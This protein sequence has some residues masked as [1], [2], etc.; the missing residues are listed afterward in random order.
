[1]FCPKCGSELTVGANFC[2][3]CGAPVSPLPNILNSAGQQ[4]QNSATQ[5]D[6]NAVN[7][8]GAF[9]AGVTQLA[10]TAATGAAQ[11]AG[12]AVKGKLI[13]ASIT[14]AIVVAGIILYNMFFVTKPLDI[15][16]QFINAVNEKDL[17]AA[18]SC[19]DPKYEKAYKATSGILSNFIGGVEITDI[20]DLF[21]LL[22]ELAGESSGDKTDLMLN[23]KG[24]TS[25][26][27]NEETA[28]ITLQLE[29]QATNSGGQVTTEEGP[30]TFYLKKF[31][32]GWRIVEIK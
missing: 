21:P 26:E 10:G 23:I 24:V 6:S 27:V 18:V 13:A 31:N 25:Q 28:V 11:V 20:A 5:I 2:G 4:V 15:V 1:M 22:Y 7:A 17:N 3:G 30:G 14:T 29:A 32:V 19:F 9:G 16:N 8:T 12:A